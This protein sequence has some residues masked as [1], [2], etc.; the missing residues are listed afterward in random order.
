[1]RADPPGERGA[2]T[3]E[4]KV[5]LRIPDRRLGGVDR[6]LVRCAG[7]RRASRR[8]SA[9]P[10]SVRLSCCARQSSASL[11]ASLA[12]CGLQLCDG[13]IEPDLERPRVDDKQRITLVHNLSVLELDRAQGAAYLGP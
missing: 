4:F 7:R 11:S 6:G 1:M 5:E 9:V 8:F 13:L 3:G 10:K 12:C 2:D